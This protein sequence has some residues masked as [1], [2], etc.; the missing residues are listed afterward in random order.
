[1]ARLY[2][3]QNAQVMIFKNES[4]T[5]LFNI[6]G[7]EIKNS[8]NTEESRPEILLMVDDII[9]NYKAH[10]EKRHEE[11]LPV[12]SK[13]INHFNKLYENQK[14]N[15]YDPNNLTDEEKNILLSDIDSTMERYVNNSKYK[16]EWPELK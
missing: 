1:M 8:G 12:I 6:N 16:G 13:M 3:D 15:K 11:Q 4:P 7:F 2:L 14:I 9:D 5:T 10:I